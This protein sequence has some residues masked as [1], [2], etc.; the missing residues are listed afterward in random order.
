MVPNMIDNLLDI[1][2]I[3]TLKAYKLFSFS[4]DG[5]SASRFPKGRRTGALSPTLTRSGFFGGVITS[6]DCSC[7]LLEEVDNASFFLDGPVLELDEELDNF[8]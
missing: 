5:V 4:L 6:R 3:M 7:V 2:F 8:L 1:D